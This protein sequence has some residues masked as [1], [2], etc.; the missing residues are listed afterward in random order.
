LFAKFDGSMSSMARVECWG[1]LY[2]KLQ[3]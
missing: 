2:G 1:Q 3:S